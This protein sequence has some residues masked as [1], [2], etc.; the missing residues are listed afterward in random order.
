MKILFSSHAFYPNLGGLESVGMLLATEFAVAGYDV[1]VVTQSLGNGKDPVLPFRIVRRPDARTLLH[2]TI[3]SD[4]VYH[5]NISLQSAWP[6]LFVRRCWVVS[7][8]GTQP[9]DLSLKGI[10]GS[11]K[12]IVL[13]YAIG[14]AVSKAV[15]L[16]YETPCKVIANPYDDK[17][18]QEIPGIA[19]DKDL[20][21]VGRF[22]SDKG[23]P[24]LLEALCS[25]RDRGL[26][27]NLTVIGTGPEDKAWRELAKDMG[28]AEQVSFTGPLRGKNLAD[29][30]NSHRILVVPSLWNEPFGIV[31]LEG[32]ACGCVV[33]GS[34]GGG[35]KEAIG[36]CGLTFPNGKADALALC[37]EKALTD[38]KI[39]A[40]FL[41]EAP[42]H[43]A[44]HRPSDIARRYSSVFSESVECFRR[45]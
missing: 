17:I 36:R 2:L 35:L 28:L 10:K 8:H 18:F 26:G 45:R 23:L 1:V 25:L 42:D 44:R 33:V 24:I 4:I 29:Q 11:I 21:F 16:N 40:D 32:I 41:A 39:V 15:A 13:R 31:A 43:L 30:L 12:R 7:H 34:E 19:R 38:Q 14:I 5:H 6:L 22:V 37:L 20:V 27:P 9:R 3:W